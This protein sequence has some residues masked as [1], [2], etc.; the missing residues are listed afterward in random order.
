MKKADSNSGSEPSTPTGSLPVSPM[1]GTP[2]GSLPGTPT[3]ARTAWMEGDGPPFPHSE[4]LASAEFKPL[5]EPFFA[6]TDQMGSAMAKFG[7]GHF[8]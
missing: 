4:Y 1:A 7:V 6:S 5:L 8:G 2:T 3:S